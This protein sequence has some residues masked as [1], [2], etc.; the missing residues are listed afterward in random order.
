MSIPNPRRAL[1][2]LACGL[3]LLLAACSRNLI[4]LPTDASASATPS[5]R[6]AIVVETAG[7]VEVRLTAGSDWQAATFGV[8]L[9]QDSQVRT[10]ADGRLFLRLTEGTKIRVGPNTAFTFKTLN[11]YPENLLTALAL[12]EGQVWVLLTGGALDVEMPG[13]WRAAARSA[14]LSVDYNADSGDVLVTCL[15]GSCYFN[16]IEIPGGQKL[17]ATPEQTNTSPAPMEFADYGVW[18]AQVP[19]ATQFA[20]LG[21]EAAVQGDATMPIVA[22]P[23]RAPSTT[24]RPTRT[25]SADQTTP[26][27]PPTELP[28]P[29]PPRTLPT[30][31]P[32]PFTPIPPAPSIGVHTVLGNETLFCIARGYGVLPGA[33]AQANGLV[34]PFIVYPGQRLNIPAVQWVDISPGPVCAPQFESPFPGLPVPTA[35]APPLPLT[36]SVEMHCITNCGSAIGEYVVHF[37]VTVSGG[38][39]PYV[40][41]PAQ[42]FDVTVPHCVEGQGAITV[43]SAD[44]QTVTT[45]WFYHDVACV[46]TTTPGAPPT[47]APTDTPG[48]L[49]TPTIAL[50]P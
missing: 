37:V 10:G 4:S 48:V 50:V 2:W 15:Q 17:A 36:V 34:V 33:I 24:P 5:T 22:T 6:N 26:P 39:E 44:G 29:T 18:G 1:G 40:Y 43:T 19:E 13:D 38:I 21:T 46:P 7:E 41:D 28:L 12:D 27:S 49:P 35:T 25:P 9:T 16:D 20:Y 45:P 11:P 8:P 42:T 14:Y 32:V 3:A 30:A 31:T 23:T 47:V